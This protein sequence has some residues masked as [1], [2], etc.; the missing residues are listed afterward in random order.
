M[1]P[2]GTKGDFIEISL[3][4]HPRYLTLLR[5]VVGRAADLLEFSEDEKQGMMLAVNE[6]CANIIEHCYA[7]DDRGKIDMT[8]RMLPDRME[9][10]LRDYGVYQEAAI[11]ES[12]GPDGEPRGLGVRIMRSAM[13]DV[14][15]RPAGRDGT[16]LT[17]KKF[18][19]ARE[20]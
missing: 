3:P 9:I 14:T 1:R 6:G 7:M 5:E 13:D 16:L 4:S 17:M 12:P 19:T 2:E 11:E 15:W 10:D 18:R 20:A 8:L